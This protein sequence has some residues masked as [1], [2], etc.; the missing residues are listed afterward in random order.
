MVIQGA[1]DPRV[2]QAESDQIVEAVSKNGTPYRYEIYQDEG[3]GFTKKQNKISSSKIILEFLDEYLKKSIF[4]E[5][6][7]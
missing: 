2:L 4:E 5:E 6:N 3:H 1:N 7:S